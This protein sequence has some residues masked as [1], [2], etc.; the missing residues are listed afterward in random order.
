MSAPGGLTQ[1]LVDAQ[2]PNPI[3]QKVAEQQLN[4]A[5]TANFAEFIR[6]LASELADPVRC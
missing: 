4:Q 3:I 1:L 2:N 6:A 5:E